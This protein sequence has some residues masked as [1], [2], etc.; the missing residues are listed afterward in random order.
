[1]QDRVNQAG[2]GLRCR[3]TLI[4]QLNGVRVPSGEWAIPFNGSRTSEFQ[5]YLHGDHARVAIAT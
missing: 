4:S 5:F 1:V 3:T 2:S